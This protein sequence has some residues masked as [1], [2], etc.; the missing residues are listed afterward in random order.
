MKLLIKL[1]IYILFDILQNLI[2]FNNNSI[3]YRI[4][5]CLFMAGLYLLEVVSG[6]VLPDLVKP[7]QWPTEP[8]DGGHP[9]PPQSTAAV[10][11]LG[12]ALHPHKMAPALG[13]LLP[14]VLV[15]GLRHLSTWVDPVVMIS[16]Q[17]TQSCSTLVLPV[18]AR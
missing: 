1:D 11:V 3:C 2:N 9:P 13:V 5:S 14:T 7:P 18:L 15:M 8:Q 10:P 12:A 6:V 17:I 16:V 4:V